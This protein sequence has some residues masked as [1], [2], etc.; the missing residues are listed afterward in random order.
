MSSP[1]PI[2]EDVTSSKLDKRESLILAAMK[3]MREKGLAQCTARAIANASPLSKSALH[4]YFQDT[5]E[6]IVIAFE[7]L[8]GLYISRITSSAKTGQTPIQALWNA[9]STYL[10]LGSSRR[11]SQIPMLWFEVQLEA[12]RSG[13]TRMVRHLSDQLYEVFFELV[14]ATGTEEP[15]R[16]ARTL[17]SALPGILLQDSMQAIDLDKCLEDCLVSMG[18]TL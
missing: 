1:K 11:S 6:I 18:F 7:R 9:S 3:V 8:I 2:L 17:F 16:K 12:S 14:V 4:Y 13:E 5:A 15:E 10:H